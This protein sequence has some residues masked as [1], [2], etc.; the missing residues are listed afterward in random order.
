MNKKKKGNLS[1][2]FISD[3]KDREIP[4][5]KIPKRHLTEEEEE[6]QFYELLYS[7]MTRDEKLDLFY[8]G[9]DK[10]DIQRLKEVK[11]YAEFYQLELPNNIKRQLRQWKGKDKY[12]NL[13]K[14][15]GSKYAVELIEHI[16][17]VF[18]LSLKG[19]DF[20]FDRNSIKWKR[21]SDG[22]EF[23]LHLPIEKKDIMKPASGDLAKRVVMTI[24]RFAMARKTHDPGP[25][26]LREFLGFLG[27]LR[28]SQLKRKRIK[29]ICESCAFTSMTIR[30]INEKGKEVYFRHT[31]FFKDF[32]WQGGFDYE[33]IIYP[34][35]NERFERMLIEEG[36]TRYIWL[37]DDRLKR[38]PKGMT[39]RDRL[40][41]DQF[42]MLL[43][44]PVV[45]FIMKN[46][47]YR[48][49]QFT[50]TE[51][52][53]MKLMDIKNFVNK[54]ISL[55]K[56][57]RL[58]K[59][60]EIHKFQKKEKYLNQVIQ[61]YPEEPKLPAKEK[62]ALTPNERKEVKKIISWLYGIGVEDYAD[63][64]KD[65]INEYVFNAAEYG[66]LD[67][68][69]L[70]Y[71]IVLDTAE[72]GYPVGEEYGQYENRPMLFWKE[73]KNCVKK[74]KPKKRNYS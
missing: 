57:N 25:I 68:L 50:D 70:A 74:K 38:L 17:K 34:V 64:E 48:F 67:C 35:I 12:E 53:K 43:G 15:K 47:L 28:A 4:G 71:Q 13:K 9:R 51:I 11:Q 10:N 73:Y 54:N 61:I 44:L 31:P 49:G 2:G 69:K 8:P 21:E 24:F 29:D 22:K 30:K 5:L 36:I 37:N 72:P 42:M 7:K 19:F 58:I 20:S 33:A 41:Q 46:W 3:M 18:P 60:A 39:E 59:K 23:T 27:E 45:R 16:Q 26:K 40:A 55:A 56:E 65:E 32:I 6:M 63:I 1:W 14:T 52:L 62:T 66:N